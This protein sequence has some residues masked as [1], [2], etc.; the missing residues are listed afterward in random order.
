MK[1]KPDCVRDVLVAL[2]S[3]HSLSLT[4]EG[5]F[6]NNYVP[7]ADLIKTLPNHNEADV[8]YAV[9][10]LEE[11][12]YIL[13]AMQWADDVLELCWLEGLTYA[14]HELLESI[15]PEPIWRKT[16]NVLAKVGSFSLPLLEDTAG[17]LIS[18]SVQSLLSGH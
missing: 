1:L 10:K 6:Y 12:G 14:G 11:A 17:Q 4:P 9:I 5:A 3:Q 13:A 16:L 15:R 8:C 7:L 2:E 18:S